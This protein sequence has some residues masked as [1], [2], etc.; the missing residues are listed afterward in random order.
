[1]ILRLLQCFFA[2]AL[3][4]PI[5]GQANTLEPEQSYQF[6]FTDVDG[7]QLSLHDGHVTLVTV[8]VKQDQAKADAVGDRVPEKYLGDPH[9]RLITVVNFK[10]KISPFFQGVASAI[11]RHRLDLEA[12]RLQARYSAKQSERDPRS[13]LFAVADFDGKAT[14]KLGMQPDSD[15]CAVFLFDGEGKLLRHWPEIPPADE[16]ATALEEATG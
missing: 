6:A 16:L 4:L 15:E 3:A 11:M 9:Y 10:K 12:V 8:I 7:N 13:D 2:A 5:T 1:M 14:S